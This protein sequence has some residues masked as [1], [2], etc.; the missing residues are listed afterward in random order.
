MMA[1]AL[2]AERRNCIV[3]G[4]QDKSPTTTPFTGIT[5]RVSAATMEHLE[6]EEPVTIETPSSLW[7]LTTTFAA[8][9][10]TIFLVSLDMT[11]VG[12]A[13]PRISQEYHSLDDVG[14]YGS[15][16]FLT[17]AA[18]QSSWGKTYKYFDIKWTFV[19]SVMIFEAGSVVC[20]MYESFPPMRAASNKQSRQRRQSSHSEQ[21][22]TSKSS[23]F[24]ASNP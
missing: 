8:L 15:A 23:E 9:V 16:F 4:K 22:E 1:R 3:A 2:F 10:L 21:E 5:Q 7:Q 6:V 13:I 24:G 17:M 18:F 20:G 12:T 11:I 14:W 19:M